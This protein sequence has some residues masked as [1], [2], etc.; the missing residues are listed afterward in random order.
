MTQI[1]V[2]IL[3]LISFGTT[4]LS[5]D[6]MNNEGINEGASTSRELTRAEICEIENYAIDTIRLLL[7]EDIEGRNLTD[8]LN[9]RFHEL[10][11]FHDQIRSYYSL[12]EFGAQRITDFLTDSSVT[13]S[14]VSSLEP[15]MNILSINYG[16]CTTMRQTR[17]WPEKKS[18]LV[19]LQMIVCAR[20][21]ENEQF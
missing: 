1:L 9:N 5:P 12:A 3:V 13:R 16:T 21:T 7:A 14:E 10:A 4:V 2:V 20:I 15:A 8:M 17:S 6:P 11:A 18:R 19:L